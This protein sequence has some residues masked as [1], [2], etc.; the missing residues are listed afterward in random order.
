MK[1]TLRAAWIIAKKDIAI[2]QRTKAVVVSTT[3]FATLVVILASLSFYLTPALARQIAPG[4]LWVAIAF[5][6]LLAVGR[7]WA[8]EREGD[9]MR[10]LLLAPVPRGAIFLGKLIANTL[11]LVAVELIVAP[12]VALFF[13]I[14]LL[15]VGP[16]LL[17][18]LVLGTFGFAAAG[19]LFGALSVRT[20]A[21]DLALSVVVF[22]LVTPALLAAVVATK[23]LFA[24]APLEEM[25]VWVKILL[26]FDAFF[27]VAGLGLFDALMSD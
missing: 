22:P 15:E 1:G 14:D 17:S 3:L 4:V 24:G 6:G 18:L 7:G 20:G 13:H 8:R 27:L 26:T 12:L 25:A 23:Q 5:S 9:A 16:A 19:T 11:F 2:E 21:R 10:A